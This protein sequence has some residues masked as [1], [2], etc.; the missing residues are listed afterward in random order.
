M[1]SQNAAGVKIFSNWTHADFLL[2]T[3]SIQKISQSMK[4]NF[5]RQKCFFVILIY[6]REN[7]RFAPIKSLTYG[8][9]KSRAPA[10]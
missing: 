1:D 6:Q 7:D 2:T 10:L 5:F 8:L 3:S 4:N 9:W